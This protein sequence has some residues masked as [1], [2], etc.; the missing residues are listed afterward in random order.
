MVEAQS[1]RKCGVISRVFRFSYSLRPRYEV[2]RPVN[3]IYGPISDDLFTI[4]TTSVEVETHVLR[5]V[6]RSRKHPCSRVDTSRKS[7]KKE[8]S[9]F[10]LRLCFIMRMNLTEVVRDR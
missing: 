8:T 4:D 2:C 9:S 5:H 10:W 6:V 3:V 1:V 7:A